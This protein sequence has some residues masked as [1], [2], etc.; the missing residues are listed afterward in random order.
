MPDGRR[1]HNAIPKSNF[2]NMKLN[3]T[4]KKSDIP[5]GA[6]AG[7]RYDDACGMAHALELLGDRWALFV[8]RELMLGPRRFGDLRNDLPGISANVL[9]QRLQELEARGIVEKSRLPPPA[10][11]QVYGLTSWGYEAD[12]IVM[13]LGRWAARSPDHDPTRP[14][15]AVAVMLSLR[16][17]L[18]AERTRVLDAVVG[19]R[20]GT[21]AFRGHVQSATLAITREEPR[22]AACTFS[23]TPAG[24]AAYVH[25]KIPLA[26]LAAAG[27]LTATGE[28]A[29]IARFPALF[30]LPPKVVRTT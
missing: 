13:A 7:R 22:D 6:V 10:N 19:F 1:L 20:F 21:L 8:V 25:G 23:G 30:H 17:L 18:V 12:V 26:T 4:T 27:A 15:S 9:T 28:R 5:T 29:L 24:L 3:K 2:Y 14:I 11:V 16:T